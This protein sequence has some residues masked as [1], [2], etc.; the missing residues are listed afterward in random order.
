VK[1][2]HQE[3]RIYKQQQQQVAA[4]AV[5]TPTAPVITEALP[6]KH[7]EN[8]KVVRHNNTAPSYQAKKLGEGHFHDRQ[9]GTGRV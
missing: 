5:P 9:S 1:R 2:T 4:K 8:A 3:K 6:E 7:K